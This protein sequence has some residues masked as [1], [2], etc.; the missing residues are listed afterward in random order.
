M[1]LAIYTICEPN[2]DQKNASNF[3]NKMKVLIYVWCAILNPRQCCYKTQE[4]KNK[5]P[6]TFKTIRMCSCMPALCPSIPFY[7]FFKK[8]Y[9]ML[10]M[11]WNTLPK[12]K[13]WNR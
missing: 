13:Q 12:A 4:G 5:T 9:H 7:C 11:N 2:F 10:F 6:K 3:I 8:A 1:Y